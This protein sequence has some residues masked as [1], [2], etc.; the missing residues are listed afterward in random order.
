MNLNN[1]FFEIKNTQKSKDLFLS[2]SKS[3][4]NISMKRK[5]CQNFLNLTKKYKIFH[6]FL[7]VSVDT[8]NLYTLDDDM[9]SLLLNPKITY[10]YPYN[11]LEKELE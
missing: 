4:R 6:K 8:P 1:K 3:S 7:C 2:K 5:R 10:N 9:N 11:N